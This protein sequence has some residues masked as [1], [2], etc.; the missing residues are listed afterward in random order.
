MA[1]RDVEPRRA[2]VV[3][4]ALAPLIPIL[5][6]IASTGPMGEWA[7]EQDEIGPLWLRRRALGY[8]KPGESGE[9]TV[10]RALL[11]ARLAKLC[12]AAEDPPPDTALEAQARRIL[13]RRLNGAPE[14]E[15]AGIRR[16]GAIDLL[17]RTMSAFGLRSIEDA[18]KIDAKRVYQL[19]ECASP[20]E[21]GRT[22]SA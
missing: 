21:A 5:R 14:L 15:A 22:A 7:R 17:E 13:L 9:T 4:A 2:N 19:R 18:E 12:D 6:E 10:E 20:P 11:D 8:H 1:A 16:G 3:R